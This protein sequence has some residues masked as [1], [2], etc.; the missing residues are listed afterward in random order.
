MMLLLRYLMKQFEC[1]SRMETFKINMEK[2]PENVSIEVD[3]VTLGAWPAGWVL[4]QGTASSRA[5]LAG[6]ESRHL[7]SVSFPTGS[8]GYHHD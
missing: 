1:L 3:K 6:G 4:L 5:W 8:P 2:Y 7:C